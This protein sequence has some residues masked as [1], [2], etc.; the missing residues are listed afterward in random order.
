MFEQ[1]FLT[2]SSRLVFSGLYMNEGM[3]GCVW[4]SVWVC[5]CDGMVVGVCMCVGGFR[6]VGVK[7]GL[8]MN[9]GVLCVKIWL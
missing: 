1:E 4:A 3:Y 5:R 9:V 2:K 8:H 6:C 7:V